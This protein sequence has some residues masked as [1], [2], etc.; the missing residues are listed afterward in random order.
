MKKDILSQLLNEA[1]SYKKFEDIEKLVE[2]GSDLSAIPVQP[3]FMALKASSKDQVSLILPK[4]SEEQ[5]QALLDI[6]IWR[7]DEIDPAA[8]NWWLDVYGHCAD[9]EIR[10]AFAKS[11]DFLLSIKNQCT[12]QI[13]DAEEPEYPESDNYFLTEDNL[14]LVEYPEDYPYA[15]EIKQLIKDLYTELGVEHAY[16]HLFKMIS[17][18]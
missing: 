12:I 1:Q 10:S 11:E 7:R 8:A 13:F 9:Q 5:R 14:L 18:S 17:D 4:L 3:L 15:S 2:V 6:D 16:T